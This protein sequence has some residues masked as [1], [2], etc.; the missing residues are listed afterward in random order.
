MKDL[1]QKSESDFSP[2]IPRSAKLLLRLCLSRNGLESVL[3]DLG[4]EY[5][6]R[7][8]TSDIHTQ[9]EILALATGA[10]ACRFVSV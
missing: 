5:R 8:G 10:I 7:R 3:G 1:A 9:R 2:T 4:E 6:S